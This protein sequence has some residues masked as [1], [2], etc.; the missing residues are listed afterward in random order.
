MVFLG[1]K[2]R[3]LWPER[4]N[5]GEV[6][7]GGCWAWVLSRGRWE[8]IGFQAGKLRARVQVLESPSAVW[9]MVL[10]A[11]KEQEGPSGGPCALHEGTGRT[12]PREGV[13]A[14]GR[15]PEPLVLG[16]GDRG[17]GGW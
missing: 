10:L 1:T 13:E 5:E 2:W 6:G 4:V 8:A 12:W 17:G 3:P 16:Q 9:T 7:R 11:R 14:A 15:V